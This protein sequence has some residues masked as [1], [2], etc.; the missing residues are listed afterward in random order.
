M[1]GIEITTKSH[2]G[3]GV[4]VNQMAYEV[5]KKPSKAMFSNSN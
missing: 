5:K 2:K 3:N 4:K 1:E